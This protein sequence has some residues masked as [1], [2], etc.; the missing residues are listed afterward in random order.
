MSEENV[1]KPFRDMDENEAAVLNNLSGKSLN[2]WGTVLTKTISRICKISIKYSI[3]LLDHE[4][5]RDNL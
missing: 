3:F 5:N 4:A 2:Q 1:L